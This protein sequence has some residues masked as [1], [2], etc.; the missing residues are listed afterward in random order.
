MLTLGGKRTGILIGSGP[1]NCTTGSGSFTHML[2]TQ[3]LWTSWPGSMNTYSKGQMVNGG[4]RVLQWRKRWISLL[5]NQ[6][7]DITWHFSTERGTRVQF[8]EERDFPAACLW[9]AVNHSD[10]QKSLSSMF[11]ML[12][13]SLP[14][15][16]H[17]SGHIL[18]F[19]SGHFTPSLYFNEGCKYGSAMVLGWSDAGG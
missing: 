5:R 17:S 1:W 3:N 18:P 19:Y 14:W 2:P 15:V 4:E 10:F 12:A 9:M 6:L 7:L 11:P 13:P 16:A 8:E